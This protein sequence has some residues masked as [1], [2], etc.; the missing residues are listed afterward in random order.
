[1]IKTN[2]THDGTTDLSARVVAARAAIHRGPLASFFATD[3]RRESGCPVH[4]V[5][6]GNGRGRPWVR[7]GFV[8]LLA[9]GGAAS[10]ATF[11]HTS[12][13]PARV[14]AGAAAAVWLV[15]QGLTRSTR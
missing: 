7:V 1:M 3:V 14:I 9:A 6:D 2:E 13:T 11:T 15:G 4:F 5:W 12:S 8:L 10:L